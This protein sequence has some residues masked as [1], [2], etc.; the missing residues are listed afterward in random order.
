MK[1]K[2]LSI[3]RLMEKAFNDIYV[4]LVVFC[5]TM[6]NVIPDTELF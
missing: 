3:M 4:T 6:R 5:S 1:A 2:F